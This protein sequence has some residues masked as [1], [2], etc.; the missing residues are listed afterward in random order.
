MSHVDPDQLDADA[1]ACLAIL[2]ERQ[3]DWQPT[4][5]VERGPRGS[6]QRPLRLIGDLR[7]RSA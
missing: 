7:K 5:E 2:I 1:R 3:A 6:I 4:M